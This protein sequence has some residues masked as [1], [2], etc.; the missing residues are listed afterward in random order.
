MKIA[1]LKDLHPRGERL[2]EWRRQFRAV[3]DAADAER[4]T[5]ILIAGDV[6]DASNVFDA[7]ASTGAIA[8]AV[9]AP[10]TCYPPTTAIDIVAITGNHDK[11]ND[12]D[13]DALT[14]LDSAGVATVV[15]AP[16]WVTLRGER[17][18]DD[19]AVLCIPWAWTPGEGAEAAVRRLLPAR[20]PGHK[21][22]ILL[23]HVQVI[24]G[25]MSGTRVCE[26]GE[27]VFSRAFIEEMS[28]H[29]DLI[30]LGD[31]H[32]EQQYARNAWHGPALWQQAFDEAGNVQGFA[33][34]DTDTG[35]RRTIAVNAS[36]THRVEIASD[37]Q[38]ALALAGTFDAERERLWIKT[39]GFRLAGP[40]AAEIRT[41]GIRVSPVDLPRAE[42]V[43]RAPEIRSAGE[44]ASPLA[45]FRVWLAAQAA[46]EALDAVEV[47]ALE[48]HIVEMTADAQALQNDKRLGAGSGSP[49]STT[50]RG[51]GGTVGEASIDWQQA[52]RVV[53]VYG[54]NGAG[55]T[56]LV[57][58]LFLALYDELPGYTGGMRDN[59][60]TAGDGTG[61]VVARFSYGGE[62]YEV[63]RTCTPSSHRAWLR[64][65]GE[66]IAGPRVTDVRARV[67]ALLGTAEGA[68]ATW[69]VA[70][71]RDND[72]CGARTTPGERRDL[73]GQ[74]LGFARFDALADEFGAAA[75]ADEKLHASQL[76]ELAGLPD[77]AAALAAIDDELGI[78]TGRVEQSARELAAARARVDAIEGELRGVD[79][80]DAG[81]R[82]AIA[83]HTAAVAALQ[84]A[85]LRANALRA[86]VDRLTVEAGKLAAARVD[87]QQLETVSARVASLDRQQEAYDA[88]ARWEGVLATLTAEYDAVSARLDAARAKA[89]VRPEDEAL[90][91]QVQTLQARG[92]D[93]RQE[94]DQAE[95]RNRRRQE[96]RAR[97]ERE[98][99]AA[100]R[101]RD[102]IAARLAKRQPT[103]FGD[104]CQTR[105]CAFLA[106]YA[107]LPARVRALEDRI[108][109]LRGE[110]DSI[111]PNEAL[112][113][114]QPLRDEYARALEAEK[115]VKAAGD[116]REEIA[117]LEDSLTLAN[118]RLGSHNGAE[119]AA[120]DDPREALRVARAR[121]QALADAP[122]RVRAAEQACE[123]LGNKREAYD[124]AF[125]AVSTAR[126]AVEQAR[127]PMEAATAALASRDEARRALEARRSELRAALTLAETEDRAANATLATLTERRRST[128]QARMAAAG[129]QDAARATETRARRLRL[130]Q[131]AFGKKGIQPLLIDAAA[132]ELEAIV[133]PMLEEATGG[134]MSLRIAT[135]EAIGDGT[136]RETFLVLVTDDRGERDVSRFSGGQR[137]KIQI[138]FRA[139]LALWLA[140]RAGAQIECLI[141]DEAFNKLHPSNFRVMRGVLDSLAVHFRRVVLITPNPALCQEFASQV[142]IHAGATAPRVEYRGQGETVGTHDH[143]GN[144]GTVTPDFVG[145]V[146]AR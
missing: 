142:W 70:A 30:E 35:E 8:E 41:R 36:R 125:G 52:G 24:G 68:K 130:L 77:Y 106:E 10:L 51:I 138:V 27:W 71:D 44:I 75:K 47:A 5:A 113:D 85:E 73:F 26:H 90:A 65:N 109:A 69:W 63:E 57:G 97:I 88:R 143:V 11:A 79:G 112:Q 122:A 55:K 103:P 14:V 28:A 16:E 3:L 78:A 93:A 80:D 101:E 119:P 18:S 50:I 17:A 40:V 53:C 111:T 81:H 64:R 66:E 145:E 128:E 132:P 105:G 21:R 20:P 62:E 42:R 25:R 110:W 140:A 115:R 4:C 48:T 123:A 61:E 39:K 84:Q 127:G 43:G 19:V 34:Y 72:V 83:A 15:R 136:L 89:N 86:D 91:A 37:E 54:E 133:N 134:E 29:V 146:A 121:A 2:A 49:L 22:A 60:C 99:D 114:L 13:P 7:H 46:S 23:A 9:I 45:A 139:G 33:V 126:G 58:G 6:F 116:A 104:E 98:R 12:T 96:D 94:R 131:G 129:K 56:S 107:A 82:A 32:A 137:E 117:R 124:D 76:A 31:F 100:I 102:Q 108:E 120:V 95:A 87:A 92:V 1:I 144:D 59:V 67:E 118:A 141:I 135:Q 74:F 38:Q